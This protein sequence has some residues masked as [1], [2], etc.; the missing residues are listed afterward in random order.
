MNNKRNNDELKIKLCE[1]HGVTLLHYS[2]VKI[3]FPYTVYGNIEEL[4]KKV[5]EN[6]E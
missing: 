1:E 4:I 2:N 6:K 3:D 5:T